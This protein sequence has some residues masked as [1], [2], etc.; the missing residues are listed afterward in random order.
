MPYKYSL[1]ERRAMPGY[2]WK[3]EEANRLLNN[4]KQR[5]WHK[6]NP[7]K[8]KEYHQKYHAYQVEYSR[9]NRKRISE[10]RRIWKENNRLR[11][12]T[13]NAEYARSHRAELNARWMLRR[14]QKLR[15]SKFETLNNDAVLFWYKLS[16]LAK[17]L[18]GVD[19]DVDHIIPMKGETVS[20]FHVS[21]NLRVIPSIDNARKGNRYTVQD[22]KIIYDRMREGYPKTKK[23]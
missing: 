10:R 6:K 18:T 20:G 23:R 22:E 8:A 4:A 5:A 3:K 17:K 13:K 11:D 19:H 7:N 15:T 12:K 16:D 9:K 1:A 2:D 14:I 21:G